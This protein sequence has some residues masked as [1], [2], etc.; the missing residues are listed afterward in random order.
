MCPPGV[1]VELPP[2]EPSGGGG[3][4]A[5]VHLARA[6]TDVNWERDV[7]TEP[8][9]AKHRDVQLPEGSTNVTI[10]ATHPL[11]RLVAICTYSVEIIGEYKWRK[12]YNNTIYGLCWHQWAI[13]RRCSFAQ[14]ISITCCPA[15]LR[16]RRS[17][18]QSRISAT[19]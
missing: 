13:R 6:R 2:G 5:H 1:L 14:G 15:M 18:G 12:D 10:T 16:R 7:H 4:R 17:A 9:W 3:G 8:S 19:M 11:S